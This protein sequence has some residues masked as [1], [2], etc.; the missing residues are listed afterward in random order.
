MCMLTVQGNIMIRNRLCV[1]CAC[2]L[3]VKH[4]LET[5]I[6]TKN[7]NESNDN[8]IHILAH[9]N[10]QRQRMVDGLRY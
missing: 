7:K 10:Q 8:E 2:L 3:H 6:T 4:N 5:N 9:P 1:S